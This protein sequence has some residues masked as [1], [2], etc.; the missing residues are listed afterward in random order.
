MSDAAARF[1]ILPLDHRQRAVAAQIHSVLRLA[2]AQE[3]ELLRLHQQLPHFAPLDTTV[4]D[5]QRSVE[6]HLGA[7][8][9][10]TLHGVVSVGPDDERD[11][12]CIG[13]LVV[14]PSAQRQGIARAL[15]QAA[16]QRGAGMVFA[17]STAA[18]NMPALALYREL[19][20]V[21]YRH[22]SIGVDQLALVKLRRAAAAPV[23]QI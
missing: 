14:H 10:E 11:Q 17:V 4:D 21:A 2:Y 6:F 3:A 5:V 19:G 7:W 20:F 23:R 16:L 15:M 13:M 12:L 18:A 9:G 8:S 22:G 1:V